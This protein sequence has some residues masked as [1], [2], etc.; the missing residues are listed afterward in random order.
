MSLLD[1]ENHHGM[2]IALQKSVRSIAVP[3][4]SVLRLIHPEVTHGSG[5]Q[6]MLDRDMRRC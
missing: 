3:W 1:S 6:K 5:S 4:N 2:G